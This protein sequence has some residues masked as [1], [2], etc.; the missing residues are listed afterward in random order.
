MAATVLRESKQHNP[1]P[2][3]AY[4]F[5]VALAFILSMFVTLF[6]ATIHQENGSAPAALSWTSF[7]ATLLVFGLLSKEFFQAIS[8][9][10]RKKSLSIAALVFVGSFSAFAISSWN[11]FQGRH[12]SLY[13]ETAAMALTLYVVSLSI[14]AHFKLKLSK[15]VDNW[16]KA[17]SFSIVKIFPND[18]RLRLSG[19]ELQIGDIFQLDSNAPLPVD[20]LLISGEGEVDESH[21]SGE[22]LPISKQ[23]GDA[24]LAGSIWLK[25]EA[26]LQAVS[27]F[28]ASSLA[29]YFQRVSELKSKQSSYERLAEKGASALLLVALIAALVALVFNALFST[30][31]IGLFNA[32]SVLLISCPCGL[33]IATPI[34]FWIAIYRLEQAGV[35]AA[36]GG[37]GLEKI[38]SVKCVLLDKTGTLTDGI[39]IIGVQPVAP[40]TNDEK[41]VWIEQALA[42]EAELV[43]P[44]A[45]AFR[46]Y[47]KQHELLPAKIEGASL[48]LG[49]GIQAEATGFD[50]PA[51]L[52]ILNHAASPRLKPN[53]LG[54]FADDELKLVFTL[55][56][57]PKPQTEQAISALQ[58]L[59]LTVAVLTGDR[60]LQPD[61]IRC[62][63]HAGLSP[64][65]KARLVKDYQKKFGAALFVG[66][67]LNDLEAMTSATA[68]MA[69]FNG[70][71]QAKTLADFTLFNSDFRT[72]AEV[73]SFAKTAKKKV[74]TNLIWSFSYNSVG[75]LLA[76]FG[77][78]NPLWAIAIMSASSS[79]VTLNSLSLLKSRPTLS[80]LA[81][82][83]L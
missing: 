32:L 6:S 1:S 69:M 50:K 67:G 73:I 77:L 33:A 72:V 82:R 45:Q 37:V 78:L 27:L 23:T 3:P 44:I 70:A 68:S 4:V 63:Y 43:H 75:I 8:Q 24:L 56:H 52:S 19:A 60:A 30:L 48:V 29:R 31:E 39:E 42:L 65:A 57:Q 34:A 81:T 38:A 61:F 53:E 35:M 83:S 17:Q 59:G 74:L 11:L 2:I 25:G 21:L 20:A 14:D 47:A 71:N 54:L 46:N 18:S 76:A 51:R 66:D 26:R 79:F 13:F 28:R 80:N 7:A 36:S 9:E 10:I 55:S 49:K 41:N 5:R 62:A 16:S 15:A 40:M 64:E 58:Q 12:Q 22:A